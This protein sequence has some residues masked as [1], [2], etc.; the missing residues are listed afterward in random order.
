MG[1]RLTA[2]DPNTVIDKTILSCVGAHWLKVPMVIVRTERELNPQT[3]GVDYDVIGERIRA[4][5]E[6]GRL[7]AA[8]NSAKWRH[9][10]VRLPP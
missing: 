8:G 7:E 9:A 1:D 6:A 5:V 10:E 3:A 2:S 4:L